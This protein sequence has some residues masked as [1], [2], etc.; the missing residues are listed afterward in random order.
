MSWI[1]AFSSRPSPNCSSFCE[2]EPL[3]TKLGSRSNRTRILDEMSQRP[4]DRLSREQQ[5]MGRESRGSFV[6]IE[7]HTGGAGSD[8]GDRLVI[9]ALAY[10][11]HDLK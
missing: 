1:V 2:I 6:A 10:A 5:S 9:S 8:V 7:D 11:R 4:L 3:P